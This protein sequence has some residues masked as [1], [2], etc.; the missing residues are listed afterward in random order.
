M[1]SKTP[2]KPKKR[3]VSYRGARAKGSRGEAEF[4]QIMTEL[5]VPTQRVIASGAHK[6]AGAEADVKVGITLNPDGTFPA[7]DETQGILRTEVKNLAV[8]P[9]TYHHAL[10]GDE[11]EI[12]MASFPAQEAS[13]KHLRQ[14]KAN[15]ALALR[16]AKPPQG[17]VVNKQF[18]EIFGVFMDIEVFA[19][20][21]RRAYPD[22]VFYAHEPSG[23]NQQEAL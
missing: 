17:A 1:A 19:D 11:F 22:K 16:R 23:Q 21:L 20:L 15:R 12:V 6:F 18:A 3:K 4:C 10:K 2:A 14:S 9:E 13:F 5:G 8:N 7:A